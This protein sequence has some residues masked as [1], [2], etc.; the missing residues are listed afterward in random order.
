[1]SCCS[2]GTADCNR[3][4][5]SNSVPFTSRFTE[6]TSGDFVLPGEIS[7]EMFFKTDQIYAHQMSQ[8]TRYPYP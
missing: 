6:D 1:M 4:A 8:L 3:K 5:P 2:E 7:P